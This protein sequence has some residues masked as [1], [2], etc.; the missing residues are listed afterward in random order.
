MKRN[1]THE[2]SLDEQLRRVIREMHDAEDALIASG[3]SQEHWLLIKKYVG[4]AIVQ[5]QI[6]ALNSLRSFDPTNES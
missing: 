5:N 2:P 4:Y 6:A 1:K 3:F